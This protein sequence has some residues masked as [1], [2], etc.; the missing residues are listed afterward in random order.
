MVITFTLQNIHFIFSDVKMTEKIPESNALNLSIR[1]SALVIDG[2]Q[3]DI[4][5]PESFLEG[6]QLVPRTYVL[7]TEYCTATSLPL[8]FYF[9]YQILQVKKLVKKIGHVSCFFFCCCY[10]VILIM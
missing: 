5:I 7:R 4:I 6:L 8:H 3:T 9:G 1:N 2:L 10:K